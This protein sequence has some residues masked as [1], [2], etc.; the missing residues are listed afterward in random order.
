MCKVV[1]KYFSNGIEEKK[2]SDYYTPKFDL[3]VVYNIS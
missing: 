3:K 1:I 2:H